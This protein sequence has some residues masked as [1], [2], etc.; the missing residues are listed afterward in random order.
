VFIEAM[1]AALRRDLAGDGANAL[2]QLL[3]DRLICCWL[4]L[5]VFEVEYLE[6][7]KRDH[8]RSEAKAWLERVGGAQ[9]RFQGALKSYARARK[10]SAVDV[11]CRFSPSFCGGWR[12]SQGDES[13]SE[14]VWL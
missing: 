11:I 14:E 9:S 13:V 7:V 10:L 5:E 4:L 6:F 2:E 12:Y 3:V 8:A 1:V